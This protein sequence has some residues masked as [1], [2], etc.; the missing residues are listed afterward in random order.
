MNAEVHA[1]VAK[2]GG[3]ISAEHGVGVMKRDLLP[4]VKDPVALDL[5]RLLKRSLDPKA[6]LNPGKVV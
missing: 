4:L 3:S 2:F 6:I 1:V 5:M